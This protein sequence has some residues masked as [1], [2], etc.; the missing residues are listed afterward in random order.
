M[1]EAPEVCDDGDQRRWRGR[2]AWPAVTGLQSCGDSLTQGTELCDDGVNDG[3]PGQCAPGCLTIQ[4]CGDAVVEGKEVCDDGTSTMAAKG[5]CLGE[6]SQAAE[7]RRCPH[8]RAPS[9]A[10]M[11]STTMASVRLVVSRAVCLRRRLVATVWSKP[12]E[13]CDDGVN[14]GDEAQCLPGC[15]K[16]QSC[17]D[18]IA[19]GTELCDDGVNDGDPGQCAP[20]CLTI[21]DLRR[22]AWSK[23][24]S[25]ATTA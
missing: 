13:L 4:T 1:V 25:S 22:R 6:L 10:T 11:A 23:A 8:R 2:N 14:D 21:R 16:L 3:D 19:E 12:P 24:K 5:E 17:G 18:N 20:G 9:S 15:A 7:L